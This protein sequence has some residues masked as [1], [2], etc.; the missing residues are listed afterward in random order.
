[1]VDVSAEDFIQ[2]VCRFLSRAEQEMLLRVLRDEVSANVRPRVLMLCWLVV[3]CWWVDRSLVGAA[4][5]L[6]V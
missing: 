5:P 2:E 3:G 4:V 6:H 1:M